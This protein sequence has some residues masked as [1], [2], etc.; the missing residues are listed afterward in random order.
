M[1]SG[2]RANHEQP[3]NLESSGIEVV[4]TTSLYAIIGATALQ[5]GGEVAGQVARERVLKPLGI[6]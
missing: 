4:L 2:Y 6:S 1:E 5:K 3:D